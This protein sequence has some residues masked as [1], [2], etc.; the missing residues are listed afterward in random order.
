[1]FFRVRLC[2]NRADLPAE[3]DQTMNFLDPEVVAATP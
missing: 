3:K 1:V 2:R